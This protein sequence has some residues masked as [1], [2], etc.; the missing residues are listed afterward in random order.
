M[1]KLS[2]AL[3]DSSAARPASKAG[4][5]AELFNLPECKNWL[6]ALLSQEF[7]QHK[8]LQ[9]LQEVIDLLQ[10][11]SSREQRL[12]IQKLLNNWGVLQKAQGSKRTYDETKADLVAKVVEETRRL[13]RMRHE[14]GEPIPNGSDTN[15]SARFSAIQTSLQHRSRRRLL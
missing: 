12:E 5:P 10:R 14:F 13:K 2:S 15:S 3:A 11:P 7:L 9:R 4:G 8:P 6:Q 1:Q